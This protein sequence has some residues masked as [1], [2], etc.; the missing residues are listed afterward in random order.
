M[1]S[2]AVRDYLAEIGKRGGQA[3]VPKGFSALSPEERRERGQMAARARWG[4]K[5]GK[6][7]AK[8]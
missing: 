4:K 8:K 5:A 6:A 2:R 3:K 1:T 7:K